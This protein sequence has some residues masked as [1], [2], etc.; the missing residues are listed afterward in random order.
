MRKFCVNRGHPVLRPEVIWPHKRKR[1]AVKWE[2]EGGN[3]I[4]VIDLKGINE[5]RPVQC[6]LEEFVLEFNK[7]FEMQPTQERPS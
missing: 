3:E 2:A 4:I 6:S 5:F 1:Q 7:F